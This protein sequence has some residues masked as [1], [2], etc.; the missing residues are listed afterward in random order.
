MFSA[1]VASDQRLRNRLVAHQIA[2]DRLLVQRLMFQARLTLYRDGQGSYVLHPFVK[3]AALLL[4]NVRLACHLQVVLLLG[5]VFL[6]VLDLHG[7]PPIGCVA[8]V[9]ALVILQ[10]DE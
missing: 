2:Q 3:A 4:Q 6:V 1:L 8:V 7:L 10:V 5:L 9:L